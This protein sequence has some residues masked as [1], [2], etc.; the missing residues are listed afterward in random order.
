MVPTRTHR[1]VIQREYTHDSSNESAVLSIPFDGL[2][3]FRERSSDIRHNQKKKTGRGRE[4]T[5][6]PGTVK[7][8]EQLL[9]AKT[10][11]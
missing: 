1:N 8:P 5:Y 11:T 4:R 9:E 6:T 3:Q 7:A 2:D 10:H